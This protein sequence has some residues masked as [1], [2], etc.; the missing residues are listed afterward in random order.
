MRWLA[1]LLLLGTPLSMSSVSSAPLRLINR[2]DAKEAKNAENP[3][4]E[5]S[6]NG[7]WRFQRDDQKE[8]KTVTLPTHW[9]T[10]EGLKF[11]G[12]GWYEKEIELP[13]LAE[14]RRL[15][16]HFDAVATHA[17]VFWNDVKLGEHLGA[18]T[19]FRFDVTEQIR[20]NPTA[21][22]KIKIRVDEKVGH[23][24]QGFLPII[25][26]HFGGVWQGVKLIETNETYADDLAFSLTGTLKEKVVN[27]IS[28]TV[29]IVGKKVSS[30]S[31]ITLRWKSALAK[32]WSSQRFDDA[33]TDN[34]GCRYLFLHTDMRNSFNS[35]YSN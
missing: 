26:P 35:A 21:K 9:E 25:E 34:Q 33:M 11:D 24:S 27:P 3:R 14:N 31:S 15:L 28:I 29:P 32:E 16:L 5:T 8:W 4:K 1:I 7:Q 13:L 30:I 2:Q 10:H 18:W 23:N 19:P 17:T 22:H 6:L 12:I 20:K